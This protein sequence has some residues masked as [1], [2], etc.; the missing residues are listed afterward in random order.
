MTIKFRPLVAR[1]YNFELPV[2]LEGVIKIKHLTKNVMC[3]VRESMLTVEPECVH[4]KKKIVVEQDKAVPSIEWISIR[5]SPGPPARFK[6]G[7]EI[8]H[9]KVFSAK[10]IE[11]L[12]EADKDFKLRVSFL[13]T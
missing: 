6:V 13:P 11:G 8:K 5:K 7:E 2:L 3:V 9:S 4:F 12:L 10:P 1:A